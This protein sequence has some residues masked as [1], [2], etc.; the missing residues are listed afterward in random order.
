MRLYNAFRMAEVMSTEATPG[1]G[2]LLRQLTLP[3]AFAVA[4]VVGVAWY[5][6]WS[7][8]DLTLALLATPMF[9]SGSEDLTLFFA[10]LVVMMVAMMLPSALP[11]V[12]SY[13]GFTRLEAG[14]PTKPT[15]LAGTTLFASAYFL[16]W[17]AF[18]VGALLGLV[19]LGVMGPLL[20][21]SI[22]VPAGVLLAA[23][24]YQTTRTK[25]LC[26]THCHS[27]MG[28]VLGHWRAGR[29][30]ALRMGLLH[31]MYC[32]GCCWLFMLVLFVTGAMSLVWMS[33]LSVA[34]FA[35]KLGPKQL[36][37]SR[38]IGLLLVVL[39]GV[40]ALGLAGRAG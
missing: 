39:G 30:G 1:E 9:A 18:C 24:L 6:T 14:R 2:D 3:V 36:L 10:L 22:F 21:P 5:V 17:G 11:M 32:V 23:G 4:T 8:S 38:A 20:G 37:I 19:A 15:D 12:L 31:A 26:L 7:T 35:E 28:F 13:A 33:A 40:L 34:I 25:D 27:P 29:V 16:V